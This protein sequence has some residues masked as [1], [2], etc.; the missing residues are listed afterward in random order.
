[1]PGRAT[2]R[3][4]NARNR[5]RRTTSG[6]ARQP[7]RLRWTR[8]SRSC[9]PQQ[10]LENQKS[11]K[12]RRQLSAQLRLPQSSRLLPLP[13]RDEAV[14]G[15]P[16]LICLAW[17][18]SWARA[19]RNRRPSRYHRRPPPQ[20]QQH[21]PLNRPYLAHPLDHHRRRR[22]QRAACRQDP[23]SGATS[24]VTSS[25]PCGVTSSAPCG[26]TSGETH[27]ATNNVEGIAGAVGIGDRAKPNHLR[28]STWEVMRL[29]QQVYPRGSSKITR[30]VGRETVFAEAGDDVGAAEDG[31]IRND[32]IAIQPPR[33]MNVAN[34]TNCQRVTKLRCAKPTSSCSGAKARKI[35]FST[36]ATLPGRV[37]MT[38]RP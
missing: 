23:L 2:N 38:T 1:M 36:T 20:F 7:R 24:G 22:H 12:V 19:N 21:R 9:R 15:T 34:R 27:G 25:A 26:G 16:W 32:L 28:K 3:T 31:A 6:H 10:G 35:P 4:R 13:N 30:K 18:D 14:I 33:A 11:S 37:T 17:A 29:P 8:V 5:L